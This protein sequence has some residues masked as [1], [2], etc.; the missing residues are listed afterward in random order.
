MFRTAKWTFFG[1]SCKSGKGLNSLPG[2]W[3]F[4]DRLT[5]VKEAGGGSVIRFAANDTRL[6]PFMGTYPRGHTRLAT[7]GC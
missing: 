1:M 4:F 7:R 3:L 2:T 5:V 6:R